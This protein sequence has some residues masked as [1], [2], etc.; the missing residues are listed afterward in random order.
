MFIIPLFLIKHFLPP[1]TLRVLSCYSY[2]TKK[3]PLLF[4]FLASTHFLDLNEC[5]TNEHCTVKASLTEKE[6]IVVGRLVCENF[7]Y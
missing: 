6:N 2:R 7:D 4:R 1:P 3:C 5:H